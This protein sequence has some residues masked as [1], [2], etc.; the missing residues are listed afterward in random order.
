MYYRLLLSSLA[1]PTVLA[2]AL[3][4]WSPAAALPLQTYDSP[5]AVSTG[6][7]IT[8]CYIIGGYT[9]LPLPLLACCNLH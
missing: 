5:A 3:H 7:Y 8:G 6:G 2:L 9:T 1:S 4:T